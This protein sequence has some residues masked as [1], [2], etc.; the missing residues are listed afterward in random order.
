[1]V[2]TVSFGLLFNPM[3]IVLPEIWQWLGFIT[4]AGGILIGFAPNLN[5]ELEEKVHMTGAVII[6]AGSQGIVILLN[7]IILLLWILWLLFIQRKERVFIAEMIGG[8]C[9]YISL[10]IVN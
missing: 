7:P 10:L 3:M 5:D 1:M 4:V 8:I 2:M 9:L 6:G